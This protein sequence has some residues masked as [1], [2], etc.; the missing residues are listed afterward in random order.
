MRM[1][2][3]GFDKG[4]DS[5]WGWT[6]FTAHAAVWTNSTEPA[7]CALLHEG[8]QNPCPNLALNSIFALHMHIKRVKKPGWKQRKEGCSPKNERSCC[9]LSGQTG[10]G[11]ATCRGNKAKLHPS[12]PAVRVME[13]ATLGLNRTT[14]TACGYLLYNQ[15]KLFS[16]RRSTSGSCTGVCAWR[17]ARALLLWNTN[18]PGSLCCRISKQKNLAMLSVQGGAGQGRLCLSPFLNN[19]AHHAA[20]GVP[21]NWEFGIFNCLGLW[22][23]FAFYFFLVYM[24]LTVN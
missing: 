3:T 8:G 18:S 11:F 10:E 16:S 9:L 23:S 1:V 12:L 6:V 14:L 7:S 4:T 5:S 21:R 13:T 20:L 24:V 2:T 15:E 19:R 22:G 17:C